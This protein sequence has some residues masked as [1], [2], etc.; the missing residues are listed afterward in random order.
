[1]QNDYQA[2]MDKILIG[3]TLNHQQSEILIDSVIGCQISKKLTRVKEKLK[4][5]DF[6]T[7]Q[8]EDFT[9]TR[10]LDKRVSELIYD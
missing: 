3:W 9:S 10:N 2:M 5:W 4:K 1:M 6:L 7:I 8:T